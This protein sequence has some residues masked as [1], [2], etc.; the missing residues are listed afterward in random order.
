[1]SC[2][3]TTTRELP[4][5]L[6]NNNLTDSSI[7][8]D[9]AEICS[10]SKVEESILR[11]VYDIGLESA[12]PK[13]LIALMPSMAGITTE[14]IKSRL[15]KCR[16]CR[17][18]SCDEFLLIY[19]QYMKRKFS[20]AE[21]ANANNYERKKSRQTSLGEEGSLKKSA[22]KKS[23]TENHEL[24]DFCKLAN[25]VLVEH[26]RLNLFMMSSIAFYSMKSDAICG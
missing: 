16:L 22:P 21:D 15:Q 11:R 4:D 3:L 19:N 18:K 6:T 2:K 1:M 26:A 12:S 23:S 25:T 14:N 17:E 10:E 8:S 9:S 5:Q 20:E 24:K 7:D 13:L